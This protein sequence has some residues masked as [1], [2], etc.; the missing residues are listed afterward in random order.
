ME[1]CWPVPEDR[2]AEIAA[3]FPDLT[4]RT[5]LAHQEV[6]DRQEKPGRWAAGSQVEVAVGALFAW[7]AAQKRR[8]SGGVRGVLVPSAD[9]R[10]TGPY[11]EFALSLS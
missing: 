7:A 4:L 6:F 2:A 10:G 5:E 11:V 1:S 8:P 9:A 3:R